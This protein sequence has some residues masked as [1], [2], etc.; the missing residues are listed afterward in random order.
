MIDPTTPVAY[1]PGR[2]TMDDIGNEA[3]TFLANHGRSYTADTQVLV[4]PQ[5]GTTY[6][7]ASLGDACGYHDAD[8][9]TSTLVYGLVRFASDAKR[10]DG[11][12]ACQWASN[13]ADNMTKVAAHEYAEMA[14][15]PHFNSAWR[16]N[17]AKGDEIA[18][19]CNDWTFNYQSASGQIVYVQELWSNAAGG[20]VQVQ[21]EE[22]NSPDR[23]YPVTAST[24]CR[25]SS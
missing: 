15:D 20:C 13:D 22:F 21:G 5:Q 25:D 23:T 1:Y 17:D 7:Q 6:D 12:P 16:S 4:I 18:D 24:R 3:P 9:S 19:L 11:S 10:P 8:L 2:M 14:T